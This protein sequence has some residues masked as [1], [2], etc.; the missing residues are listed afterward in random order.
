M[1]NY[2][3]P[4]CNF[5][6]YHK[7]VF[8]KHVTRKNICPPTV[9]NVCREKI[10]FHYF[11]NESN[12]YVLKDN[13]PMQ[14]KNYTQT[15]TLTSTQRQHCQH[16]IN[17]SSS[18]DKKI[19]K[20][21]TVGDLL[22]NHKIENLDS[23]DINTVNT[24]STL[25]QHNV[26]TTSTQGQHNVN[27]MSTQQKNYK[28]KYCF[29]KFTTRQSRSRHE[30]KYCKKVKDTNEIDQNILSYNKTDTYF[31]TD[32]KI[33]ECMTKQY[34]SIPHL[35]KM[36]HFNPKHPENHNMYIG[37]IKDKY[38]FVYNGNTWE[39]KDRNEVIDSLISEKEYILQDKLSTWIKNSD[40]S[41]KYNYAISK[42][43]KYIQMKENNKD[44]K[45]INSIKEEIKLLLYN[46]RKLCKDN[47]LV[48]IKK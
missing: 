24:R 9:E 28:C 7:S 47:F 14:Q 43:K 18:E 38:I 26:N 34:M 32:N 25:C 23:V 27:T 8:R 6:T 42:F 44:N 12:G 10:I 33:S 22:L 11:P 1:V 48:H 2:S 5:S 37:N 4:R 41:E 15:S 30:L 20:N 39:I 21:E 19:V 16:N 13:I 36:V 29:K 35:I 17:V 31:I 3:C 40:N 45:I 46:N